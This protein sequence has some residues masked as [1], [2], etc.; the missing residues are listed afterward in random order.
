M[1]PIFAPEIIFSIVM[2]STV[3]RLRQCGRVVR[4]PDL[5]SGCLKFKSHSDHQLELF[6]VVP[7]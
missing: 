7:G 6:W 2:G 3:S 5:K 4:A 1:K